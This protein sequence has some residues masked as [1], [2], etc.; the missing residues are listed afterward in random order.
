M[1]DRSLELRPVRASVVLCLAASSS[2]DTLGVTSAMLAGRVAP[3]ELLLVSASGRESEMVDAARSRLKE[4]DPESLVL[5]HTD[6]WTGW[7][8]AGPAA[9]SAFARLSSVPLPTGG[10]GFAQ[11]A[12]C[13]I[14]G[15]VVVVPAGVCLLVSSSQGHHV[16]DRALEM[17]GDL[18]VALGEPWDFGAEGAG[19]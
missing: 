19:P 11:G 8:L 16:R 14:G 5:A 4:S 9:A 2:L 6:A 13:S 15:K 10:P 7:L 18:G 17:C 1:A 3:D 12:I